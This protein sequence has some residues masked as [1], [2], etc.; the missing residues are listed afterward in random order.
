MEQKFQVPYLEWEFVFFVP[1]RDFDGVL[2]GRAEVIRACDLRLECTFSLS[3]KQGSL[4]QLRG[5][6]NE[7]CLAW[8]S[9]WRRRKRGGGGGGGG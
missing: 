6:L 2:H 4:R 3:R 8:V 1:E 9:E 7:E 5:D